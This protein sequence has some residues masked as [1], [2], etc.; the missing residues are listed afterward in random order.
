[1][2]Q[3]IRASLDNAVRNLDVGTLL[4]YPEPATDGLLHHDVQLVLLGTHKINFQLI[5]SHKNTKLQ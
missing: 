1:M 5:Q 4:F 2:F 3:R